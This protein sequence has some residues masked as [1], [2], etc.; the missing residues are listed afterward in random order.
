MDFEGSRLLLAC[1]VTAGHFNIR[2]NT[3]PYLS[4]RAIHLA[5]PHSD[6]AGH[7]PAVVP[8]A[9]HHNAAG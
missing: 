5:A 6:T 8:L 1:L 9:T 4:K 7:H 2:R 3:F